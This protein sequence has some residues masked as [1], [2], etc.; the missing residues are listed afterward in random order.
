MYMY[1]CIKICK[2][3]VAESLLAWPFNPRSFGGSPDKRLLS[4]K[5]GY[6]ILCLLLY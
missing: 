2:L 6:Y 3:S 1:I 4:A 5:L